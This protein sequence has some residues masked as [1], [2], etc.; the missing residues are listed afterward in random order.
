MTQQAAVPETAHTTKD[1]RPFCVRR[2]RREDAAAALRYAKAL[3]D[4][5][6]LPVT[7]SPGEFSFSLA[8]E[9]QFIESHQRAGAVLLFAL[10]AG[11][12]IGTLGFQAGKLARTKHAGVFGVS[13]AKPWRGVGVGSVLIERLLAWAREHPEIERVGLDVFATNARAHALYRRFG[14]EEEGRRRGA[15]RLGGRRVDAIQMGLLLPAKGPDRP[16]PGPRTRPAS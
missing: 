2:A 12:V 11:E 7:Y 9:E 6:D 13:V 14:F 8:E 3:F 1:N 5:P 4:E 15:I 16:A 10:S